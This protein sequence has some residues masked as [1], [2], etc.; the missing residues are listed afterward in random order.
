MAFLNFNFLS[1]HGR[2]TGL[3]R[4]LI[5]AGDAWLGGDGFQGVLYGTVDS[6]TA[7][8]GG[9]QTGATPIT[10]AMARFTTVATGG[11]S[12]LLPVS[13]PGMTITVSN[14]AAANSMNVFPASGE[15]I[16]ALSANAA[17]AV[18]AGKTAEF[19]CYTAGQWH[20]ILSA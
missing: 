14:A 3:F 2:L 9:G 16:N 19:V 20:T 18:A 12:A 17:F 6:L 7:L 11:D 13:Q 8:A 1:L 10:A 5:S 4:G 15:K